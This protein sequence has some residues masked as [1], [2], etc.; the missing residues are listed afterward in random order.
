MH[1]IQN[2][3]LISILKNTVYM[4]SFK[5]ACRQLQP[6]ATVDIYEK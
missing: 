3:K 6:L 1:L 4:D 2:S 5:N